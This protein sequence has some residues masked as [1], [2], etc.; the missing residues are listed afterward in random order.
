MLT[1]RLVEEELSEPRDYSAEHPLAEEGRGE[2]MLI[3]KGET[4]SPEHRARRLQEMSWNEIDGPGCY[5][6]IDSG[7]LLRVPQEQM[8]DHCR[9]AFHAWIAWVQSAQGQ[10]RAA[11]N[12]AIVPLGSTVP[13]ATGNASLVELLEVGGSQGRGA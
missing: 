8:G 11:G 13:A 2:S 6:L 1:F 10:S 4:S 7:D 12:V 3:V 9:P 5:V